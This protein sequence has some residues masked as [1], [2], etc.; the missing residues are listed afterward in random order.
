VWLYGSDNPPPATIERM[1]LDILKSSEWPNPSVSSAS[2]QPTPVTGASGV[3]M[4]G[5][6]EYVPPVYWYADKDAGGAHGYNTET[7]PGPAIP[8]L[9]SVKRFI[10]KEHLWPMDDVWNYHAGGERFTTVNVFTDGLTRR[11]GVPKSLEDYERKSQAMTYD[12]QRAMFEAYGRNKY[13]STGVIQWMLNNS[14][15]SLIWHLYDYYLVPGGGYFGTKKAMEPLH[16]QYD[17]ADRSV[18]VVNDTY[19]EHAGMKVVAKIYNLQGKQLASHEEK[20]NVGAD[21]SVKAFDLPKAEGL[22]MTF[23]VKLEM[24]DPAGKLVSDNFYWLSAKEDTLDWKKRQDTVY[25]PQAEFADLSELETLPEAVVSVE[26]V[27]ERH[28]HSAVVVVTLKN[29]SDAVAF[30]THLRLTDNKGNEVVPV[31]WNDNYVSLLPHEERE[32][33]ATYDTDGLSGQDPIVRLDGWN[34]TNT[35]R[36]PVTVKKPV[37]E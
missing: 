24:F 15:P 22:T 29:R 16:V 2:E 23:F 6:Y 5:P 3:K 17:Y 37:G 30:M 26:R 28:E 8:T 21:A 19:E 11:Y 13:V 31:F 10:P 18:S 20:V 33:W 27:F 9:E 14:W 25:T 35:V 1:Y 12:G 34:G 4:T 36:V 7:S 32:I